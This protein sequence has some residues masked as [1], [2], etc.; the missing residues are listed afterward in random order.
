MTPPVPGAGRANRVRAGRQAGVGDTTYVLGID[1]GVNLGLCVAR[2]RGPGDL[3]S[4]FNYT[5]VYHHTVTSNP[6]ESV[7]SRLDVYRPALTAVVA[8]FE[9]GRA[10]V[11]VPWRHN[12]RNKGLSIFTRDSKNVGSI[13][14]LCAIT[15]MAI[16]TLRHCGVEVVEIPAPTGKATANWEK[17]KRWEAEQLTGLKL[18]GHEAVAFGLVMKGL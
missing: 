17:V 4:K 16:T 9:P 5:V 7:T 14:L 13:G 3:L 6:G 1:P 11:E 15:G 10:Y 18:N 2:R 8:I 12:Q